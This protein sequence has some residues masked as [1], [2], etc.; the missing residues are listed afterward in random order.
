MAAFTANPDRLARFEREAKVLAALNH[1]NIA[2]VY[3]FEDNAIA[4]ELVDGRRWP[5]GW[6][7]DQS[8]STRRSPSPPR[9]PMRSTLRTRRASSIET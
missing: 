7:P 1:P 2:Q 4:M 3:G 5:I 9:S 6:R 8:R